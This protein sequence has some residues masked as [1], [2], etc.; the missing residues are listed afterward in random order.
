L[1]A[2]AELTA[3]YNN[4]MQMNRQ[5]QQLLVASHLQQPTTTTFNQ[6]TYFGGA[7]T[8][9][10]LPL[11]SLQLIESLSPN[12]SAFARLPLGTSSLN[13]PDRNNLNTILEALRQLERENAKFESV[14]A[15]VLVR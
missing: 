7:P 4:A 9:N 8:N 12:G 6:P 10:Q 5:Q 3:L 2:I 1:A 13:G 11:T 14:S 15:D